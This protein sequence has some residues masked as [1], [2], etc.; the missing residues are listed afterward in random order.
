ML[1]N[2]KSKS[3]LFPENSS[4]FVLRHWIT[5]N[6]SVF[7]VTNNGAQEH[8]ILL[9]ISTL[10][11]TFFSIFQCA[12]RGYIWS[13]N[14]DIRKAIKNTTAG[15]KNLVQ[16]CESRIFVHSLPQR[17]PNCRK[18]TSFIAAL[19]SM[20]THATKLQIRITQ[21]VTFAAMEAS[22]Q[23]TQVKWLLA[24][25]GSNWKPI[26]YRLILQLEPKKQEN[27]KQ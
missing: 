26:K 13:Q 4:S 27:W 12:S 8:S 11:P 19:F 6:I 3:P 15:N 22:Q 7:Q 14:T 10:N 18:R 5:Y 21:D 23:W 20:C 1:S 16:S 17:N 9:R 24:S 25:T 2:L